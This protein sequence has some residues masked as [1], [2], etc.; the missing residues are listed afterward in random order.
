MCDCEHSSNRTANADGTA[1]VSRTC[2]LNFLLVCVNYLCVFVCVSVCSCVCL[3]VSVCVCVCLCVYRQEMEEQLKR[4]RERV[5][6][7]EQKQREAEVYA[8]YLYFVRKLTLLFSCGAERR[9][10][11]LLRLRR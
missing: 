11:Q 4:Q 7:V 6:E 5:A 1:M 3:C 8:R 9:Q 2:Q 10:L